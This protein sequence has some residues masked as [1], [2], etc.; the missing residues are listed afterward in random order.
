MVDLPGCAC[1]NDRLLDCSLRLG[2]D[3]CTAVAGRRIYRPAAGGS[4]Y[5]DAATSALS[6][7]AL[8]RATEYGKPVA[9]GYDTFEPPGWSAARPALTKFPEQAALD[10][11]RSFGVKYIVVSANAYG[12]DW[13][14]TQQYL[15][16]IAALHL[17]GQFPEPRTWDVDPAVIDNRPDMEEYLLPDNFAVFELLP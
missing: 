12:A 16:S 2:H 13:P 15:Q 14:E 7:P 1:A 4:R 5:A 10:V 8:F 9:Y 6:G 11:L 3:P 17:L